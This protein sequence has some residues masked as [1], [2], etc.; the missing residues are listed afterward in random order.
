MFQERNANTS[1]KM[2]QCTKF[3]KIII[4]Q[5]RFDQ[6]LRAPEGVTGHM[7]S[8]LLQVL[9]GSVRGGGD[10]RGHPR[11]LPPRDQPRGGQ[12]GTYT[13]ATHTC[14]HNTYTAVSPTHLTPT[15][16]SRSNTCQP[17]PTTQTHSWYAHIHTVH[18]THTLAPPTLTPMSDVT[19]IHTHT[20]K[21]THTHMFGLSCQPHPKLTDSGN[22]SDSRTELCSIQVLP[23]LV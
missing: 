2:C 4:G 1:I 11:H 8:V 9:R 7:F 6:H 16:T 22:K 21:H 15:Q 14:T 12:S 13:R 23:R 5:Q 10:H 3:V 19:H 20:H 18:K 17:P